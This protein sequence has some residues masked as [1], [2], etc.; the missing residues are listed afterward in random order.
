MIRGSKLVRFENAGHYVHEEA[1]E[2][3]ARAILEWV[4]ST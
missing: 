2:D 4:P 1:A 3:V